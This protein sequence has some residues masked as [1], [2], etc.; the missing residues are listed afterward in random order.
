MMSACTNGFLT[1]NRAAVERVT[2]HF[3]TDLK[4]LR[5]ECRDRGK[6]GTLRPR[7]IPMSHSSTGDSA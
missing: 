4:T 6:V 5:H 7:T 1:E 2:G 3:G